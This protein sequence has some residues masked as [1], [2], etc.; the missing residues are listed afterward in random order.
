MIHMTRWILPILLALLM[1]SPASALTIT[2]EGV[3]GYSVTAEPGMVIY[4][5]TVNELPIGANQTH[6]LTYNGYS[7]L[8]TIGTYTDSVGGVWKNADITLVSPNGTQT[9]HASTLGIATQYK[10]TIQY[11]NPQIYSASMPIATVHL[12]VG[13]NPLDAS[14]NGGAIWNPSSALPFTAA[15][16]TLDGV[17]TVYVEEMTTGDF[18]NNVVKYNPVY[19][20]TNLGSQVFQWTWNSILGF[21]A[22]IPVVGPIFVQFFDVIGIVLGSVFFWLYFVVANFPMVLCGVECLIFMFAVI[23]TGNGKNSLGRLARNV[24]QYNVAFVVGLIALVNVVKDWSISIVQT[25]ASVVSAL[26]PI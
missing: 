4:Q 2:A 11:V 23:N 20:I 9:V 15:S 1:T 10:T 6:T 12:D 24:Y 16:G 5:I 21:V 25:V 3:S 17:T 19:G 26:K 13:M 14:F 8:L 18:Q 22:M 7:Y